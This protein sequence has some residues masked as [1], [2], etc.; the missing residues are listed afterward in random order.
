M[1]DI[2]SL[3]VEFVQSFQNEFGD[4]F[5]QKYYISFKQSNIKG[6]RVN[7]QKISA[8]HFSQITQLNLEKISYFD[9]CFYVNSNDK[10]GNTV[11]HQA[12]A[13][14]LQEP[15]SMIPVAS[16]QNLDFANKCILDLCASPGGKTTQ[17]ASLMKESTLLVSNEI[18]SKR[19]DVL[20]QN[21]ERLGLKNIVVLNESPQNLSKNLTM[22]FD[23][24]F[25]DA[26]C[27]GEGMFRKDNNAICEWNSG[28]KKFN[29]DRQLNILFEADKMLKTNGIIVYS[30]CTFNTLENE[31]TV[32]IFCST[33]NYTIENV[34]SKVMPYLTNGKM[35]NNNTALCKTKHFFPF[36]SKGEG[37][38]VAIL[39]K[40]SE[41]S[42][43][44]KT[45]GSHSIE[46]VRTNSMEYKIICQFI[47]ENLNDKFDLDT[48]NIL[49]IGEK[50]H[51]ISKQFDYTIYEN[52][53]IKSLGVILGEIVKNRLEVSHQF[54]KAY[55]QYFVNF[56]NLQHNSEF[57]KKYIK[58]EQL[59]LHH[60]ENSEDLISQ[61]I[62]HN[63]YGVILANGV[64]LGGIKIINDEIKNHYP[65]AL[66]MIIV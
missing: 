28:L 61:N 2:N 16:V 35:I 49:K 33:Q 25:V 15:S 56:I 41:D 57:L 55:A 51:I 12:G 17:I 38:Y 50:Y 65:K 4:D 32:D 43:R 14:Y 46:I 45:R 54:C 6:L 52:L 9:G 18:D 63:G 48:F 7:I 42:V 58:G 10:L 31:Q 60:I 26:P 53:K 30:T 27:S 21:V 1:N 62:A 13:F 39:K 37:Q 22:K 24:I 29:H 23:I 34:D 40:L 8:E 66:R 5:L 19:A 44:L 20:F 64:C 47:H 36:F 3:P 11:L 59:F